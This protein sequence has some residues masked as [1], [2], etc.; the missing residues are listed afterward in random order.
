MLAVLEG[1]SMSCR[2]R[3]VAGKPALSTTTSASRRFPRVKVWAA[4]LKRLESQ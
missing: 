1:G 2:S 3:A 4:I